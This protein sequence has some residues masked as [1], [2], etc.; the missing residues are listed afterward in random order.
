MLQPDVLLTLCGEISNTLLERHIP[1]AT[2]VYMHGKCLMKIPRRIPICYGILLIEFWRET[3]CLEIKHQ[4]IFGKFFGQLL[5]DKI[6]CQSFSDLDELVKFVSDKVGD[7]YHCQTILKNNAINKEKTI[8][9][10]DGQNQ[11][12]YCQR[13]DQRFGD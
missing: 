10:L 5:L 8:L 1:V 11:A 12:E 2:M 3:S 13:L 9:C 4:S 7:Y 6:D